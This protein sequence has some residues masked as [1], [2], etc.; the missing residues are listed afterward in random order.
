MRFFFDLKREQA[1][2]LDYGGEDF[3]DHEVAI[4]HAKAIAD[5]MANHMPAWVGWTVE[6][7]DRHGIKFIAFPVETLERVTEEDLSRAAAA[8]GRPASSAGTPATI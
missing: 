7:R 6:V 8:T 2:M 1:R 3:L 5:H 4:N